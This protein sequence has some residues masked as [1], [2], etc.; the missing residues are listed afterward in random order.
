MFAA[1]DG[2][3][4]TDGAS[5]VNTMTKKVANLWG[6]AL[7]GQSLFKFNQS[8][9]DGSDVFAGNNVNLGVY[10]SANINDSHYYVSLATGGFLCDLRASFGWTRVQSGQLEI[11]A[12]CVD[13]DQTTNRIYAVKYGTSPSSSSTDRVIRIDRVVVPDNT[14]EDADGTLINCSI[15]T[16]AYAEGDPA[17]KRRYRHALLTYSLYGGAATYPSST[18]YPSVLL[19][20]GLSTGE[21]TVTATK[22]LDASGSTALIGSEEAPAETQISG[23]ARCDHQTLSQ[24]VTYTIETTGYPVAFSL[25]EITNGFNQLRPGRVV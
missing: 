14:V 5:L 17:Q 25:F 12:A 1:S 10:G 11:A 21:F 18:T 22:G 16:R 9:F 15:T 19:Y 6:D 2:V 4:L 24:A 7:A 23:V 13:S 20:P 3:Y 8:L